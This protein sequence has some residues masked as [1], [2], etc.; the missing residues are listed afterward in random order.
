VSSASPL[1]FQIGDSL[2][3]ALDFWDSVKDG[4]EEL[5]WVSTQLR[6]L[7]DYMILV[8]Q[9]YRTGAVEGI[10]EQLVKNTLVV[11]KRDIDKLAKIVSEPEVKIRPQH[12]GIRRTWKGGKIA[13]LQ[14][15]VESA[16]T[17]RSQ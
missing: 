1:A 11:M 15:H 7:A 13:K 8:K 12:D 3:K 9:E 2:H 14:G 6:L 5:D 17:S 16:M 4:P 10:Q